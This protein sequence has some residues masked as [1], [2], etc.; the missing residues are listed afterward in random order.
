MPTNL[1]RYPP[2]WPKRESVRLSAAPSYAT[3][4]FGPSVWTGRALQA[5][6]D[7]LEYLRDQPK[8]SASPLVNLSKF[9]LG[10]CPVQCTT[11]KRVTAVRLATYAHHSKPARRTGRCLCGAVQYIAPYRPRARESGR[12][13]GIVCGT[14]HRALSPEGG[15]RRTGISRKGRYS[16]LHCHRTELGWANSSPG[17]LLAGA[18]YCRMRQVTEAR[19]HLFVRGN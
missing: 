2:S 3:S 18:F 14:S 9:I 16:E 1:L 19:D 10:C 11:T 4:T 12:D 5:E 7:D 8:P 17:S 15:H 13:S 6:S